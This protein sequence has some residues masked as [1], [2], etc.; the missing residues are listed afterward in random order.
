MV[1]GKVTF[2]NSIIMDY[3]S[4]TIR[5]TPSQALELSIEVEL[6]VAVEL[7]LHTVSIYVINQ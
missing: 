1:L 6:S 2:K 5:K 4:T 3:I 7:Y